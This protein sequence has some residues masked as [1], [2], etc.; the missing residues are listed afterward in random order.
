[1]L[2]NIIRQDGGVAW[3]EETSPR[4]M[5]CKVN[6]LRPLGKA[7]RWGTVSTCSCEAVSHPCVTW[8][9][10]MDDGDDGDDGNDGDDGDVLFCC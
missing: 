7:P 2:F 10:E 5:Y 8:L 6:R 3:P 9:V 4:T 1:M